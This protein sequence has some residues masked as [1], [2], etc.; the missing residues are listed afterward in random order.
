MLSGFC[1]QYLIEFSQGNDFSL[2]YTNFKLGPQTQM[3]LNDPDTQ[4]FQVLQK[5]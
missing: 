4:I 5:T 1:N 3:M 2:Y